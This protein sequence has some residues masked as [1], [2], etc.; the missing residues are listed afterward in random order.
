MTPEETSG[1]YSNGNT[2]ILLVEDSPTDAMLT[3][4]ALA[5]HDVRN[6]LHVAD[7]G[8]DAM[9]FLQRK[10]KYAD[11]DRP[12]LILLDLNLPKKNGRE[13]LAD[14]K[15]DPELKAIPVVVLTT[16][17]AQEDIEKS[18]ELN[19]NCYVV[20]PVDFNTF[21]DVIRAIDNFWLRVAALP[22]LR[23]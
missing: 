13:V 6:P 17:K 15:A 4:A 12:G 16:S 9:D 23:G 22:P 8:V 14:I 3:R 20:K 11:A 18:Y 19:A 2:S 1:T 5:H 21:T 10:G 7:D